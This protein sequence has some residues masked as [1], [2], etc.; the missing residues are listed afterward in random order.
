MSS[1]KERVVSALNFLTGEGI[2]Y[3]PSG[4]DNNAI[5]ALINDYF[6]DGSASGIDDSSDDDSDHGNAPG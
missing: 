3:Y 5:E 6:N 4:C 2:Q 1:S